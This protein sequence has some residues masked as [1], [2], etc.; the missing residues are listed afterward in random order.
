M[1]SLL[2][3]V[4]R[5]SH[6]A[7]VLTPPPPHTHTH[8]RYVLTHEKHSLLKTIAFGLQLMDLSPD[9][10]RSIYKNK[11]VNIQR[12]DKIFKQV[13]VI[14]LFGDM[15]VTLMSIVK[16]GNYYSDSLWA[17]G[18]DK[19]EEKVAA[20]EYNVLTKL[21]A[22]KDERDQLICALRLADGFDVEGKP[23]NQSGEKMSDLALRGLQTVA[24]WTT[25]F[26]ELYAWKLA[27]PMDRCVV[28][29][30][31]CVCVCVYVCVC[32]CVCVCRG[33]GGSL[34]LQCRL[35]VFPRAALMTCPH[36]AAARTPADTA[37][38]SARMTSR[39]T[40]RRAGTTIRQ[41]RRRRSSS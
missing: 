13:P 24:R 38:A 11:A 19:E 16:E 27:H 9:P 30:V 1:W 3:F 25:T 8:T 37:T 5:S 21:N 41:R 17:S 18:T 10:K 31:L 39:R 14:P 29:C 40:R 20:R 34:V 26:T 2:S 4:C 12:F 33:R 28:C 23:V 36:P 32:A 22:F 35:Y 15:Q 6:L 7:A